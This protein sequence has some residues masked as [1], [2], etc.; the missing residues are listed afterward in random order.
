MTD[1]RQ[2]KIRIYSILTGDRCIEARAVHYAIASTLAGECGKP[3]STISRGSSGCSTSRVPNPQTSV[4]RPHSIK[5][6]C[7]GMVDP[8][9]RH[10]IGEVKRIQTKQLSDWE[11]RIS[12]STGLTE[13]PQ[14]A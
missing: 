11:R 7:H 8:L 9:V 5:V 6:L 12:T 3:Y 4:E 13:G 2:R 10:D 14:F 1:I